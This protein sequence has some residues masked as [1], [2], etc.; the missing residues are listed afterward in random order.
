MPIALPATVRQKGLRD[1]PALLI[2]TLGPYA[3]RQFRAS[4]SVAPLPLK[5]SAT[6]EP[7]LFLRR[8]RLAPVQF[9]VPARTSTRHSLPGQ[10]MPKGFTNAARRTG[11][12]S[13]FI[14]H[15]WSLNTGYAAPN[16]TGIGITL[17]QIPRFVMKSQINLPKG[18][19]KASQVATYR[20]RQ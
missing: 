5:S 7:E 1:K 14:F 4:A 13:E 18:F 10:H 9:L 20:Q 16:E 8:S 12:E 2:T 17:R 6:T 11:N 19:P 15:A 3:L